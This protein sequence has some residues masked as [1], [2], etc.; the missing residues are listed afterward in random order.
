[1]ITLSFLQPLSLSYYCSGMNENSKIDTDTNNQLRDEMLNEL[2]DIFV[3]SILWEL[4][5]GNQYEPGSDLL[6]GIYKRT[7]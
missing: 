3:E 5:H 4:H 7:S 6:P 2:A 1:M